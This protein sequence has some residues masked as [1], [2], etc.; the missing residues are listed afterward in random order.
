MP[1]LVTKKNIQCINSHRSVNDVWNIM[2][3]FF[4]TELPQLERDSLRTLCGKTRNNNNRSS[5]LKG[6]I[7]LHF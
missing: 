4:L 3:P 5:F 2:N 7:D 1:F 6:V